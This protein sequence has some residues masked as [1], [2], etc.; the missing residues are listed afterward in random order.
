MTYYMMVIIERARMR[1]R[2][3]EVLEL[4]RDVSSALVYGTNLQGRIRHCA[5]NSRCQ[6]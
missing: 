4:Q 3:T 6:R 5:E 2:K 1:I